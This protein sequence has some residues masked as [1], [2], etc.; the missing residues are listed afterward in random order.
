MLSAVS[1][2]SAGLPIARVNIHLLDELMRH[3]DCSV[4]VVV[5]RGVEWEVGVRATA[6]TLAIRR[7]TAHV[8]ECPARERWRPWDIA[9]VGLE[10]VDLIERSVIARATQQCE[11]DQEDGAGHEEQAEEA[12]R[13][14]YRGVMLEAVQIASLKV[15]RHGLTAERHY[16][17]SLC[18]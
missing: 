9:R 15:T 1:Y 14:S 11:E 4:E 5:A 13:H 7:D 12:K 16:G 18:R 6:V 3:I 2:V 10:E 17:V 8:P